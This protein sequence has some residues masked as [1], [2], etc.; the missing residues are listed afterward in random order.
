M[1]HASYPDGMSAPGKRRRRR[2]RRWL[3]LGGLL[4]A[5]AWSITVVVTS[6]RGY[7]HARDGVAQLEELRDSLSPEQLLR[8]EGRD[9]LETALAEFEAA[10]DA[11]SSPWLLPLRP[12]PVVGRQI[13]S[14]ESMSDATTAVLDRGV[15]AVDRIDREVPVE[16]E[17][18]PEDRAAVFSTL[19]A[20]AGGLGTEVTGADLGPAAGLLGPL[21]DARRRLSTEL[22]GLGDGL[23]RAEAGSASLASIFGTDGDYL[24]LV[25]NN[26]EARAGGGMILRVGRLSV[27]DGRISLDQLESSGAPLETPVPAEEDLLTN[28]AWLEP[29]QRFQNVGVTPR[30]DA[31]APVAASIWEAKGGPP[32]D[33]VIL[34]DVVALRSILDATGPIEVDGR[35]VS[36]ETVEQEIFIDQYA[37]GVDQEERL[38]AIAEAT[39]DA[40]DGGGWDLDTM[41]EQMRVAANGRH[42]LVWSPDE[43][44][45]RAWERARVAGTVGPDSLLVSVLNLGGNKLDQ[46]LGVDGTLAVSEVDDG[47]LVTADL[48]LANDVPA[49]VPPVVSGPFGGSS[50]GIGEYAGVVSAHVPGEATRLRL[51]GGDRS[52]VR[53]RDGN[54]ELVGAWVRIPAGEVRDLTLQFVLPPDT[55]ALTVDPSGRVLPISWVSGDEEWT[56]EAE[57]T[58]HW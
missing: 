12:L 6:I 7:Q 19:E 57:H 47:W 24:L 31:V 8:G 5:V 43:D 55:R 37:E 20:V 36:A 10:H 46:F 52:V 56:D 18:A 28:W 50:F 51:V 38:G 27:R 48:Q 29:A 2:L 35:E 39:F 34:V 25:A 32:V 42:V 58:L 22:A 41:A 15:D 11:G 3:L 44:R 17:I 4:V 54:S 49:D 30:F 23:V 9:Q 14:F 26:A 21:D 16:G 1:R 33:G 45:Q 13:D 53:G 40:L